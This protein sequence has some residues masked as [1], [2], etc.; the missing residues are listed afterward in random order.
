MPQPAEGMKLPPG[1]TSLADIQSLIVS[2]AALPLSMT[3]VFH[4]TLPHHRYV[5][6]QPVFWF[7]TSDIQLGNYV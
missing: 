6:V 7:L 4:S 5:Q 1:Y 2:A 3:Y